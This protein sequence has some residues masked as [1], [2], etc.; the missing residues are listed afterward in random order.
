MNTLSIALVVGI[1]CALAASPSP[2]DDIDIYLEAGI[3]ET[4]IPCGAVVEA[5]LVTPSITVNQHK[6]AAPHNDIFFPLF[7]PGN[8]PRWRGNVKKLKV[9]R[10][11]DTDPA[12]GV[13]STRDIIAQAPLGV[14]PREGLSADDGGILADALTFWT[15]PA[16]ADVVAFDASR[17]EV[18]G[19]DGRS[20]GRGGAGQQIA[21][22][23]SG[24]VGA[25]NG[26][27]GARQLFTLDPGMSG[28]LLALDATMDLSGLSP[29]LDPGNTMVEQQEREL[30]G[31]IRG[32]DVYDADGD[33]DLTESRPWLLG[34][35]LHSRP[36]VINYGVRPGT[37]YSGENPDVRLFFGTNDGFFH[38]I[39]N[40][41]D[42]GEDKESGKESWAFIPLEMLAMQ[43]I[44]A[45]NQVQR[46]PRHLYGMDG[47][48]VALVQ[49]RDLDG[50]IE[51]DQGDLVWVFI[52]QRRGGR[53]IYAFDMTDPDR[54]QFKWKI[55]H[56]TP[57]F[58]QLAMTF[59]TPRVA[60]LDLGDAVPA[61]VL[62][63]GGGYNGG[64]N[65][66]VRVGKDVGAASD[67][68]G[69]AIYVVNA[70]NGELIWK[71]VGPDGGSVPAQGERLHYVAGLTD[72][73]PS[74]IA[75]VDAD[76]NGL[77][78]RAYVGD[79]GGNVWRVDL[80]GYAGVLADTT[81]TDPLTWRVTRLAS[82]GGDG[83][84][85]RR[86]FHAPD[87]VR[88]RD[89]S[90]DYDGVLIISGNRA[91]PKQTVVD[92]YAYLLKDRNTAHGGDRSAST[93]VI[94]ASD[95]ADITQSCGRQDETGCTAVDL[96][97]GWKL[98]LAAPGEKGLS[99]PLLSN[100]LVLF[101]SYVPG[102]ETSSDACTGAQGSGRVYV[103]KLE[104]A[105]SGLS[106]VSELSP[107][108]AP[109]GYAEIGPGIPADV[110]PYRDRVLVPGRGIDGKPFL[111][112]PGRTR[113]RVYW[114]EEEVDSL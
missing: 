85:D 3:A 107:L 22:F 25:S 70:D 72:S 71:A 2:A 48:A 4:G 9:V 16:G 24:T 45:A 59:S 67:L 15:D 47:E 36:L 57:G 112:I 8:K 78:D 96:A 83:S 66:S 97:Y 90:G 49:D 33:S 50:N 46:P 103:V 60:T 20:V 102:G 19:R 92:N 84:N 38:L 100:G 77:A 29:F 34:D 42:V 113:W 44:L 75:V 105:A 58:E 31:W 40:T 94:E 10:L 106:L 35:L 6:L 23:L 5:S 30:L 86:F 41:L 81:A 54:P 109:R 79:S 93:A 21:G 111:N 13:V 53:A 65:G 88:T 76:N 95:L 101:S 110:L 108:D 27:S 7:E 56:R 69:N 62:V 80:T 11:T 73:I 18:S 98:A 52:G 63:F 14:N 74:P 99:S 12:T 87:F 17:G 39:N 37:A 43:S 82:L 64:W 51:A 28:Q 91:A 89:G 104:D 26:E 32:Q 1:S 114:R 61:A 68:I 55:S